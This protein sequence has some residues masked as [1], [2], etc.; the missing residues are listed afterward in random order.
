MGAVY[1][2]E[3][4]VEG[5]AGVGAGPTGVCVGG[6]EISVAGTRGFVPP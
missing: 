6:A 2:A 3:M 1:G 4:I 5:T